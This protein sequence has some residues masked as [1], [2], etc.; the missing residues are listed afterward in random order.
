VTVCG[1][2]S[3]IV[4]DILSLSC[5]HAHEALCHARERDRV[6]LS[7]SHARKRTQESERESERGGGNERVSERV[8]LCV[9]HT[10]MSCIMSLSRSRSVTLS[11]S[12]RVSLCH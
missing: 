4:C 12:D 8:G 1:R 5:L 6:S 7:R 9:S 2:E 11:H 3:H 10:H